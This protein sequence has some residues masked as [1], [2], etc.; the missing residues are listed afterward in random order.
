MVAAGALGVTLLPASVRSQLPA[1][2]VAI[3][4]NAVPPLGIEGVKS[5]DKARDRDGVKAWAR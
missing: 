5:G 4:L 1:L 2:K 3:D